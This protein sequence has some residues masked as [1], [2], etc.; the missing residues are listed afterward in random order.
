MSDEETPPAAGAA[1]DPAVGE[2]ADPAAGSASAPAAI[3]HEPVEVGLERSV[4]YGRIITVAIVL[5]AVIGAAAAL[6]FP[7]GPEA[8]YELGQV[9]GLM[10]VVGGAIGL[11]LGAVLALVLGLIA[12]RRRGAALA[13]LT[14]VR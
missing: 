14:D 7:V 6:F 13:V 8:D 5:G 11:A 4:R 2:P 12:R 9:V 3:Q 10:V 1:D